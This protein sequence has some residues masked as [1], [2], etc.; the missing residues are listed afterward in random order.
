[1][2]KQN[3]VINAKFFFFKQLFDSLK[4]TTLDT[5]SRSKNGHFYRN[6]D[7]LQAKMTEHKRDDIKI[8]VKVFL[9]TESIDYL[10]LSIDTLL[11]TLEVD[12]L[13][14][15]ILAYHP[16]SSSSS[17]TITTNGHSHMNGGGDLH[18]PNINGIGKEGVIEWGDGSTNALNSLKKL[19]KTLEQYADEKKICQLGIADLDTESLKEL[20]DGSV[21]KPTIAQIN[22]SA[23]CVVPPSMQ[24]FCNKNFIQLLTHSDPEGL[25]CFFFF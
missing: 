16:K 11:K 1:M 7:D 3:N 9:N 10:R 22:L 19:W 17:T 18:S 6:N 2:A 23:C 13:D 12:H 21:V 8:G 14:N 25:F 15:L 24:E 4:L 20:Y 5:A